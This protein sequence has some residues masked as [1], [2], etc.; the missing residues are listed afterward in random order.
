MT[1]IQ[2]FAANYVALKDNL[3][4]QDKGFLIKWI[5]ENS[6]DKIK[7]LL[8]T[9][10]Y[11]FQ[12]EA[13]GMFDKT[14]PFLNEDI[15]VLTFAG[16]KYSF[17]SVDDLLKFVEKVRRTS[18]DIGRQSGYD[19]GW[20]SGAQ[21]GKDVGA[22]NAT[23]TTLGSVVVAALVITLAYK[24]YKRFLSKAA[25]ACNNKGGAEKTSCMNK[26]KKHATQIRIKDLQKGT[27]ACS[28]TKSPEK[29]K[30]KIQKKITKLKAQLGEL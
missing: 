4:E 16:K 6:D 20:D 7:S 29:C 2:Y 14:L 9:G 23:V 27:A 30:Q 11:K 19:R 28:K 21:F 17:L 13:V 26:Y 5:K 22:S 18:Y 10:N 3:T 12:Q 1:D 8:M 24:T 15:T 25:R